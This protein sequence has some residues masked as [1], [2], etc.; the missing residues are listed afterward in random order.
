LSRLRDGFG[1]RQQR[2]DEMRF[3]LEAAWSASLR[4]RQDRWNAATAGLLRQ[5][6]TRRLGAIRERLTALESRLLRA[7]QATLTR[8]GARFGNAAARLNSLSPLAVLN[9]GYALVFD[10]AGY[11]IKDA[12]RALPGQEVSTRLARGS[13]RSRIFESQGRN[14]E[15]EPDKKAD[16]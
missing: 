10:D 15:I 6:A 9:R 13:F 3:R 8:A 4:Q 7:Q 14:G 2:V 12:A 11:L 5:D 16:A 1:R